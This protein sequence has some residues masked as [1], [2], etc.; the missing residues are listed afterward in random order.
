MIQPMSAPAHDIH[1]SSELLVR[2]P[3]T[4]EP[5]GSVPLTGPE[6][7]ASVAHDVAKVQPL[8]ALLRLQDRARYM[9]RMAQSVIDDFDELQKALVAEQG[10]PG[11]EVATLELLA[12]IDALIWIAQ[13]GAEIL[14][15]RSVGIHRSMSILKR[16]RIA[17]EPYGV[18][19]VIGAGSAPS[20]S[21]SDRS[22][23]RS[24]RATG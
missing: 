20:P 16:G 14:G 7:I 2:N 8:W 3:A 11:A 15:A 5:L 6:Q 17:Y 10:R 4:G 22:R 18:V 13:D 1:R 12:A 9:R 24:W 21:R 23:V 19:G